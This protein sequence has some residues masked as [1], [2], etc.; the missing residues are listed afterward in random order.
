MEDGVD[1]IDR[2]LVLGLEV[3][4]RGFVLLLSQFL[5]K[6]ILFEGSVYFFQVVGCCLVCIYV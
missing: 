1:V 6:A 2:C 5:L 4:F 3:F